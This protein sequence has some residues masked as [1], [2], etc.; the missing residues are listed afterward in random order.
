MRWIYDIEIFPNFFSCSLKNYDTQEKLIY[1]ISERKNDLLE[2]VKLF[3]QKDSWF[4]GFNTIHYDNLIIMYLIKNY[5]KLKNKDYIEITKE[6]KILN[7]KIILDDDYKQFNNL[8]YNQPFRSVDIFLYW[9]KLLRISKKLSLKSLAVNIN[10][11]KIQDLPH[12]PDHVVQLEEIEEILSYNM[13]DVEIVEFLAKKKMNKDIN[14]RKDAQERYG[15]PCMSWDGVKLGL[16]VL[17]K[18]YCERTGL[19]FDY[20][21]SLRTNR[22]IIKLSDVILPII[23]FDE[24]D[25]SYIEFIEEKQ[26][27]RQFKSFYGLHKF[28]MNLSVEKTNEINCRIFYN[29][30]RYDVK[31]GGLH[32]YHNPEVVIPDK[33]EIY[34]DKD[35]S[36]YYPTLGGDWNFIPEHLGIEFAEELKAIKLERLELKHKG[37]GKSS[38][39]ELLKLGMNGGFYGNTNNEYTPMFDRKCMFSITINGQLMLLMLCQRLMNIGVKIDMCNTDG[40]T[41]RY[42]KHLYEEV[43]NICKEW[44]KITRTE[45]ETVNY[46]KVIRMNINNYMAFYEDK[47]TQGIKQKGLFLTDPPVDSSRDFLV[48]SKALRAYYKDDILPEDFIRNHD[49]IY[50]FTACQK[51]DRKYKV[52][53][54]NKVQQR[55]NRYYVSN[56]GAFLYKRKPNG[57]IENMLKGFS[58]NLFNDYEEREMKDYHINY[59]YYISQTKSLINDLESKQLILL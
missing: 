30:N 40:I 42:K 46:T 1:E 7:D 20:V 36:S 48:I 9:S 32:T 47:G 18:R 51:V 35:V 6:L 53:W 10:W 13:N 49:N 12:S 27:I 4:I 31:S 55:I 43:E 29:G 33:D 16:N 57:N 23:Q 39:A 5:H 28:L 50:D 2:V 54:N 14:L 59:D 38:D 34:A 22:S 41:I 45:L 52:I 15:F 19:D 56:K 21:N 17:V 37:L 26:L 24:D 44:E 11:Y 25:D 3:N 8:K 58:V